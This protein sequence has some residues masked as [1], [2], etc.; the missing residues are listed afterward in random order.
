MYIRL[1]SKPDLIEDIMCRLPIRNV[2]RNYTGSDATLTQIK[3]W[4]HDCDS[5]HG[6]H[7]KIFKASHPKR[8]VDVSDEKEIRV[9]EYSTGMGQYICLSHQWGKLDMPLKLKNG[10]EDVLFSG[11][12]AADLPL[13]FRHAVEITRRLGCRYLWI[14][15]LCIVQTDKNDW[16]SEGAKMASIYSN[17]WLT[18]A[19]AAASGPTDGLFKSPDE[20]LTDNSSLELGHPSDLP[21][22]V[23]VRREPRFEVGHLVRKQEHGLLDRAWVLQER[24]ISPRVVFFGFNEV[25]WECMSCEACSC[26]PRLTP[27]KVQK[28]SPREPMNPKAAFWQASGRI[29]EERD[30]TDARLLAAWHNVVNAYTGL[31]L[32]YATDIFPALAGLAGQV[33]ATRK[34]DQYIA[35]LWK[36]TIMQDLL[37]RRRTVGDWNESIWSDHYDLQNCFDGGNQG[38]EKFERKLMDQ[39]LSEIK[40]ARQLERRLAPSWSWASLHTQI[41]YDKETNL[42][43][44]DLIDL[45]LSQLVQV[46]CAHKNETGEL[47]DPENSSISLKGKIVTVE[48]R[49]VKVENSYESR[50]VSNTCV[51][52]FSAPDTGMRFRESPLKDGARLSCLLIATG[53]VR[54]R[55]HMRKELGLVLI[56]TG[57]CYKRVGMFSQTY[58]IGK[59]SSVFD[60]VESRNLVRLV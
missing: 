11:I 60:G 48:L 27:Y 30:M 53:R 1:E 29:N 19:A 39:N 45:E 42:R 43:D 10:T 38:K 56:E 41:E 58:E 59:E 33:K 23:Y 44:F 51:M 46:N 13:T 55:E 16:E 40:T 25:S 49:K 54:E 12:Q 4:Q 17:S 52:H 24:L 37:W 15:S 26:E 47:Q 34:G 28:Y 32:T 50:L 31:R 21:F 7:P 14:D 57:P 9:V 2:L 5:H 36:Q 8:C 35:G 6:C 3:K 20:Q 22:P 18:V